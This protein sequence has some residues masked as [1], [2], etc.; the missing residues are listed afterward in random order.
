MEEG[1]TGKWIR[2]DVCGE[3][4]NIVVLNRELVNIV[5]LNR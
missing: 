2:T 4:V 3:L 1:S 5:V